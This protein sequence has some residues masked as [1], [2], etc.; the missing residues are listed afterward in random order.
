MFFA[1]TKK[2]IGYSH[3]KSYNLIK[4]SFYARD[5]KTEVDTGRS[6]IRG[7]NLIKSMQMICF[8]NQ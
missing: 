3:K 2:K 5:K 6:L 7:L 8:G 1:Y 4:F